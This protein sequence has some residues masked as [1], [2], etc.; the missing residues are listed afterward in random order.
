MGK[1]L[2]LVLGWL[3]LVVMAVSPDTIRLSRIAERQYLYDL[4]TIGQ[5]GMAATGPDGVVVRLTRDIKSHAHRAY[6]LRVY[7]QN[8][9]DSAQHGF[10]YGS[11]NQVIDVTVLRGI[12]T[13]RLRMGSMVPTSQWATDESDQYVPVAL[14]PRE[15]V[16][17]LIRV[18]NA[19]SWLPFWTN[20]NRPPV[21][22]S[23][24][25]ETELSHYRRTMAAYRNNMPEFQYRS[26]LQGALLFFLIFVG[27]LYSLYRQRIYRYYMLYVL[28]GCS[29]AML[30]TRNYT[31]VGH[32]LSYF[33]MLR[34]HLLESVMWFGLGAYFF[35]LTELLDLPQHHPKIARWLRR[36]AWISI[37]Y[38][39]LYAAIML[40][41]N[42]SGFH[43]ATFWLTRLLLIPVYLGVLIWIQRVVKSPLTG[44][45]LLGNA[46]M[47]L[48]GILAWLRA[49][50]VILKGVKLPG[51][52]DDLMTVSFAVLLEILVFA[53]AVARRIQLMDQERD[54]HQ[55]AYI[56][57]LEE[58]RRLIAGVNQELEAKVR[59]KTTEIV[60]ANRLLETQ[61]VN[62]LRTDYEKR[63]A[64]IEMLALRSQMNPHF[65]F[66]S[67]NTLEYFILTGEE[68]KAS[69]YLS[70]FSRLLRMILNHSREEVIALSDE[71]TALRLYLDIEATRFG[72]DFQYRIDIDEAI[73]QQRIIIPPL[74]LQPFAEN[75][76]WHGLMQSRQTDKRLYVRV[77]SPDEQTVVFEVEDNGIGQQQAEKL[78]R[79]SSV[80][81]KS[82]GMEITGQRIE[83]FNRNYP[84]TI[85]M[86]LIDRST[87]GGTGT[88][89]QI[90]YKTDEQYLDA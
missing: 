81:R 59:E 17:L 7:L 77:L 78:K 9:T 52:V 14:H 37:S 22:L 25:V 88:L 29:F 57:Q 65:L 16:Q 27:L 54:A 20:A 1:W 45:V 74:L 84:S 10:L 53:L 32:W 50:E 58:N 64:E 71:L 86:R 31:P 75:A 72:D 87:P 12:R 33:P 83:L 51:S 2:G 4:A 21:R 73:D 24:S 48:V 38:G 5:T 61:R 26:W 23:L 62:Q 80:K 66:N 79:R 42:D 15:T 6:W 3:P 89:V 56:L 43:Q 35:F 63:I 67:L 47:A 18:A 55:R 44:Y 8:D 39:L 46:L 69:E 68:R 30:K 82:Y 11:D 19:T 60:E 36:M 85:Q 40:L 41:T 28:A 76:I 70:T 90:I 49:G 13:E 34:T